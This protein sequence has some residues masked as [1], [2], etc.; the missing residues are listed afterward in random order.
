MG[1]PH[2][3]AITEL[4]GTKKSGPFPG[5]FP[6]GIG[7]KSSENIESLLF[8]LDNQKNYTRGR[9]FANQSLTK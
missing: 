1:S 5:S 8:P 7:I 9:W 4:K 2:D 6:N 3:K